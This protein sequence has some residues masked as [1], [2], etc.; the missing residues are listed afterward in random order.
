MKIML[1]TTAWPEGSGDP[2]HVYVFEDYRAGSRS[3]RAVAYVPHGTDPV[4]KFKTP[5]DI[6]LRGRTFVAVQ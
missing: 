6:D 1:E 3:A 2:N 4:L 5:L